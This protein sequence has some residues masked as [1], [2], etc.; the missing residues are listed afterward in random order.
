MED[1]KWQLIDLIV[2]YV[3]TKRILNLTEVCPKL[4]SQSLT[5][6]ENSSLR[7]ALTPPP[8]QVKRKVGT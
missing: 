1:S 4:V 2:V 6:V 7:V 3:P 8:P 5:C